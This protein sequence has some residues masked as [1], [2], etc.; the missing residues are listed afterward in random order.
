MELFNIFTRILI[1]HVLLTGILEYINYIPTPSF[2][3]K[4]IMCSVTHVN[5]HCIFA[6]FCVI[7][8]GDFFQSTL[9]RQIPFS[10]N[11]TNLLLHH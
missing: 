10:W 9:I 6:N 8:H 3:G 4:C 7:V 11:I 2:Q 5:D 1:G